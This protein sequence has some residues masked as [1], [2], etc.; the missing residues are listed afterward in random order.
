MTVR[1]VFM[2]TPEFAVPTLAALSDSCEV[3]G[4]FTRPDAA[5]GR[6]RSARPSPVKLAAEQLGLT[7][8][9]PTTLRDEAVVR[10]LAGLEPELIVVAAYGMILP[11]AVLDAAVLGAVNVHASLLPRWRGAAP[12]QRAIL[13]GDTEVGVSIMQMEEGLDTGPY[14]LQRATDVGDADARELTERLARIGADAL[15]EVLPAI[16]ARRAQW[17]E[18]DD[19]LATYADKVSKTDVAIDPDLPAE[20]AL[21]HVRASLPAAPCRVSIADRTLT[22]VSASLSDPHEAAAVSRGGVALGA[23]GVVLGT[24]LGALCVE[25][26]KPDGKPEMPALDWAR[27]VRDLAG[28][29]WNRLA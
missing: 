14:C 13:A 29:A 20:Q 6:G 25:R 17:T 12:I 18:Q 7:V 5:S 11:R 23:R 1:V 2:G 22:L 16:V 10:T 3:V 27:G 21:R 4:V 19:L 8:L 24:A 9:Q 15:T 28:A 26:L